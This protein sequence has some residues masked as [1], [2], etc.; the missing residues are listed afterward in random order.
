[1]PFET[2]RIAAI[3]H[4]AQI[5]SVAPFGFAR[6]VC[7]PLRCGD[8]GVIL[9]RKLHFFGAL[10]MLRML[11]RFRGAARYLGPYPRG[12]RSGSALFLPAAANGHCAVHPVKCNQ[13]RNFYRRT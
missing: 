10:A 1:V 7:G 4:T 8:L 13:H 5:V 9:A 6:F 2:I 12:G 3:A 11:N